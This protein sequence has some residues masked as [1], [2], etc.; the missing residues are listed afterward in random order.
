MA[1]SS[2]TG[3]RPELSFSTRKTNE[4]SMA[5]KLDKIPELEGQANFTVWEALLKVVFKILKLYDIVVTGV[6][7]ANDA[8]KTKRKLT[9]TGAIMP[10]PHLCRRSP[11]QSWRRL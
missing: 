5:V 7:P 9:T 6:T 2:A 1:S 10:R 8:Q 11:C 4:K 3:K